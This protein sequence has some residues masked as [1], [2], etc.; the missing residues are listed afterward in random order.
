MLLKVRKSGLGRLHD[1][2]DVQAVGVGFR[3]PV[4]REGSLCTR[5]CDVKRAA[6]TETGP[7]VLRV[8]TTAAWVA[9]GPGEAN[10]SSAEQHDGGV[11]VLDQKQ[12][13]KNPNG[14]AAYRAGAWVG[15][16]AVGK[17]VGRVVGSGDRGS[18]AIR[19]AMPGPRTQW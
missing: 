12:G 11:R 13:F 4:P 6:R 8:P 9:S 10:T 19:V 14:G 15:G 16:G 1:G 7:W 17:A 3:Q 2:Q 18:I 5:R